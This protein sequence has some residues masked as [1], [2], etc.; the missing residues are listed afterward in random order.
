MAVEEEFELGD[1]VGTGDI[2]GFVAEDLF[3]HLS[4]FALGGVDLS[5]DE[6]EVLR[7]EGDVVGVVEWVV[8]G[9]GVGVG[10]EGV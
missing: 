8:D 3:L 9:L 7:D 5:E 2:D 1:G 10:G 4:E 6:G